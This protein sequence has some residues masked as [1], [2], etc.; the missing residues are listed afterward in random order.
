MHEDEVRE[1]SLTY[2]R[3]IW[4]A[5][6]RQAR[7]RP[8]DEDFFQETYRRAFDAAA[9]L[10]SLSHCRAWLFRILNSLVIDTRRRQRRAPFLAVV[11]TRYGRESV[12]PLEPSGDFQAEMLER[13]SAQEIGRMV[14]ALPSEQRAALTLCDIEGF[15]YR[16]IADIVGCP[17][18]TVRSRIA[19]AR[20]ALI[21]RLRDRAG[22]RGI[23]G[24][25]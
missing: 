8:E 9:E 23:G 20:A 21:E 1:V 13:V 11:D 3:Q 7:D 5:A 16:E 14:E 15:S 19:R 17:V 2:Q 12:V 22:L 4:N 6:L 25:Q 18:G 10:R 24:R